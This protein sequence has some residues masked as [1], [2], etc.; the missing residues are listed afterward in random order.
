MAAAVNRRVRLCH[1]VIFFLIASQV[2]DVVRDPAIGDLAI[3][4]FNETKLIDPRESRHRADQTD[5]RTFRCL[6]RT[7]TPVMG[8]V[9]VA[10]FESVAI[11]TQSAWS[12]RGQTALVG[13]LRQ[14]IRLIHELRELRAP[15]EIAND[16]AESFR[17]HQLL[18]RH[19]VDIDVEQSHAL[20]D[21]SF[22]AGETD[23]ALIG[24]EFAD[25]S[26]ATATEVIDVV[27]RTLAATEVN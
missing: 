11:A 8:R 20:F 4:C 26:N 12:E 15:E 10:Y 22:R 1:Q 6:N 18:R 17:I 7:T 16:R 13:Q 3:W 5:V 23:A 14:R 19:A 25:R 21:E 24:Q 27:E 2:I 9:H